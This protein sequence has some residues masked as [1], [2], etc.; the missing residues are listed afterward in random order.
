MKLFIGNVVGYG[1]VQKIT[2]VFSALPDFQILDRKSLIPAFDLA[3]NENVEAVIVG[4]DTLARLLSLIFL[5]FGRKVVFL[6]DKERFNISSIKSLLSFIL[7]ILIIRFPK[8]DKVVYLFPCDNKFILFPGFTPG[9]EESKD[10]YYESNDQLKIAFI[11]RD[12]YIKGFDRF[13][14]VSKACSDIAEFVAAGIDIE[15]STSDVRCLGRIEN[16]KSLIRQSD[17]I[18]ILSREEGFPS[19]IAECTELNKTLL[20]TNIL[21]EEYTR[22]FG[23]VV[24]IKSN[25]SETKIIE[26]FSYFIRNFS[27]SAIEPSF[28]GKDD[29]DF[30]RF[31]EKV[32]NL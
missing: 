16:S 32:R 4:P 13:L 31:Q 15:K 2:E 1:G 6:V 17:L 30:Y 3:K 7:N 19:L 28:L 20:L 23:N 21:P 9:V 26:E 11:G 29:F 12:D 5:A 18:L 25:D 22:D 14:K 24:V 10:I 27:K 8:N